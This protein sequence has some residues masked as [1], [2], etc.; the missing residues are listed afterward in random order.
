MNG[1]PLPPLTGLHLQLAVCIQKIGNPI[2]GMNDLTVSRIWTFSQMENDGIAE[3]PSGVLI[4]GQDLLM[5]VGEP[6]LRK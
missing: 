6:S 1:V 2:W 5:F 4:I 3:I